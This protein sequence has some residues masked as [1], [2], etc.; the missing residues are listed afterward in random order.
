MKVYDATNMILGRLSTRV[1]KDLLRGEMVHIVNAEKAVV[2]GKP[3]FTIAF[4]LK[5][6]QRGDPRHG[7]FYPKTPQGIVR[8]TVRGMI[9]YKKP[10]GRQAFK[11]LRVWIG[12]P[13]EFKNKELVKLK[14]ADA[15]KLR[16]KS[17]TVGE[18]SFAIGGKKRW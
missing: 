3:Q 14:E 12:S 11:R 8:R 1:A 4:Y 7:P 17:I 6:I 18:L 16:T 15:N 5:K 2:S 10:L 9:P 13:N